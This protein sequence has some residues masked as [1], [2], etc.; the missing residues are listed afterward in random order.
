[1]KQFFWTTGLLIVQIL[2]LNHVHVNGYG[3]PF[4]CIFPILLFPLESSRWKILFLGFIIGIIEDIFLNTPGVSTA[5]FTA[6]AMIQPN[7]LK[8]VMPHDEDDKNLPPSARNIGWG[9]YIKYLFTACLIISLVFFALETFSFFNYTKYLIS[10]FSTCFIT[11]LFLL[12]IEKV[13]NAQT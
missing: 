12:S 10:V 2:V 6:L 8:S 4:V 11:F 13:R 5:T 1:M 3:T 9:N 7:L